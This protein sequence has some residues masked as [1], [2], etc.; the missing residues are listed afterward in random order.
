MFIITAKL[1]RV[2]YNS[3]E[4]DGSRHINMIARQALKPNQGQLNSTL[5]RIEGT[6]ASFEI[7]GEG[8]LVRKGVEQEGGVMTLT[9][10]EDRE[11]IAQ[12]AHSVSEV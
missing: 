1:L 3:M 8:V 6:L 5:N 10:A 9:G 11:E 2:D 12:V 7:Q 4:G